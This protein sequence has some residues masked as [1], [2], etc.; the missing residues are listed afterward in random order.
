MI[1]PIAI[2][3]GV[4]T[5]V[6]ANALLWAI[7]NTQGKEAEIM[8]CRGNLHR[9]NLA[10]KVND[11]FFTYEDVDGSLCWRRISAG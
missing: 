7:Y 11:D 10:R 2:F 1:A 4:L 6:V 8:R 5:I 9:L 3:V